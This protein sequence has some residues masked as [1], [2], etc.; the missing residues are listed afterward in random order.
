MFPRLTGYCAI[1]NRRGGCQLVITPHIHSLSRI[2]V[3]LVF[4][5]CRSLYCES[6]CAMVV[7]GG[8]TFG[9]SLTTRFGRSRLPKAA[10]HELISI[11]NI[12]ACWASRLSALIGAYL[13]KL[14]K[15]TRCNH[16][17]ESPIQT[18]VLRTGNCNGSPHLPMFGSFLVGCPASH[19][20]RNRAHRCWAGF[21]CHHGERRT[22]RSRRLCS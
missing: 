5:S 7:V 1:G 15:A 10:T 14:R 3:H 19:S 22:C 12:R 4:S 21:P 2:D 9:R 16:P 20:R 18:S 13:S 8:R 6:Q 11:V 17:A